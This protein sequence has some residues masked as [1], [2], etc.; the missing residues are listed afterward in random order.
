VSKAKELL[1][2][3]PEVRLEEGLART[4]RWYKENEAWW[5]PQLWMRSVKIRLPDGSVAYY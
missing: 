1:G 5:R 2:W 3:E 4:V